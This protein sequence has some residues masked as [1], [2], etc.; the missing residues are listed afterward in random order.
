MTDLERLKKYGDPLEREFADFIEASV[1]SYARV[2]STYIGNDGQSRPIP[3]RLPADEELRRKE[4]AQCLYTCLESLLCLDMIAS[5]I[6]ATP[7]VDNKTRL[8]AM[9]DFVAAYAHVGRVR[10]ML[11][12][13]AVR[14]NRHKQQKYFDGLWSDRHQVLHDSKLPTSTRGG[15]LAVEPPDS[16]DAKPRDE[17]SGPAT[18]NFAPPIRLWDESDTRNHEA[19]SEHIGTVAEKATDAANK[20]LYAFVGA[21]EATAEKRSIVWPENPDGPA[22]TTSGH[23]PSW[24]A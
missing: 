8:S 6:R 16:D 10:D 20:T 19:L 11:Q 13:I 5:R 2:W 18:N 1:P 7:Q 21:V 22:P 3:A 4:V 23:K 9:N 12:K 17:D 24:R 15:E 14:I